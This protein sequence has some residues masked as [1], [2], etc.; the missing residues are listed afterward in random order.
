RNGRCYHRTCSLYSVMEERSSV[1]P[2]EGYQ[3]FNISKKIPERDLILMFPFTYVNYRVMAALCLH[4]LLP[5]SAAPEYEDLHGNM[6][7]KSSFK[8]FLEALGPVPEDTGPA[9]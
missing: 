7:Q 3:I 6:K 8:A 9:H 5:S 2:S 4:P 1:E